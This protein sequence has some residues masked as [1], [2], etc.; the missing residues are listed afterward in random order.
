MKLKYVVGS[1]NCCKVHAVIDRLGADVEFAPR[2][3]QP[4]GRRP[5]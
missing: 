1:P 2:D 4:V 5:A 3:P